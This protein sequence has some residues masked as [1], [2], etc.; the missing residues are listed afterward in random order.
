MIAFIDGHK[1]RETEGLRWGVEPIC[2][3]LP[4]APQTYYAY[5]SRPASVRSLRD[6]YL[7]GEIRRV[8]DE[9]YRVYGAEKIW[10]QLNREGIAVARC[11]VER[12]MRK[13]GIRG[14][15]RGRKVFTTR[16]DQTQDRPA[17]LLMRDFTAPAPN[18]R[19][20]ADFTYVR[21]RS[22]FC[23]VALVI[24]CYARVIVGWNVSRQMTTDLVLTALEQAIFS[25]LGET[26]AGPIHHSD[27]GSQYLAIRYT[28]MLREARIDPSVGSVGDSYDNALAESVIGL[29]KTELVRNLG[30]WN[31]HDDLELETMVWV[32]WWNHRRLI[33]RL[34]PNEREEQHYRRTEE[35]VHT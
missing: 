16:S 11:T 15:V 12:L 23:Y 25:R 28:Q 29:Y 13:L 33:D 18:R 24:D 31:G 35:L 34:T 2:A 14:A 9:N 20:V 7:K 8:S 3:E 27:A 26:G 30:P 19:W 10:W 22:G 1:E 21:T 17:D 5:K 32:H 6:E 4:I